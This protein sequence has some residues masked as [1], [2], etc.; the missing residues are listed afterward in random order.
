M[1]ASHHKNTP[2]LAEVQASF[3]QAILDGETTILNLIPHSGRTSNDVLFGVYQHAYVGRLIEV[4]A[5]EHEYLK[6]YLGDDEFRS[7]ATAFVKQHPSRTQN[8]RWFGE[9]L[10]KFLQ[11]TKPYAS[12]PELSELACLERTLA[13]AFDARDASTIALP[14]LQAFDPEDWEHL[15][16]TPHPSGH[17]LLLKTNALALW[18]ALREERTPD[19]AMV[20]NEPQAVMIWRV[21]T[22][23]MI[24][25]MPA[26]EAM[27][28]SEAARGSSFGRLCE[29][30]AVFDDPDTA[31]IRAATHLAGWLAN[32]LISSV[33]FSAD[34]PAE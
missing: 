17:V 24:R 12:H 26:E 16:F 30:L 6:A 11:V 25:A 4:V 28:W 3:Q 32:G 29:L 14:D 18:Q 23:P 13:A 7:M 31:P 9:P 33:Q 27:M 22:A 15:V 2:T 10:P 20:L 19:H 5:S 8:A 34:A 21:D 1:T